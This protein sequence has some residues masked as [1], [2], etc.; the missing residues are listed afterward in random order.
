MPYIFFFRGGLYDIISM[1][2]FVS[3][4]THIYDYYLPRAY[5]N[6][7]YISPLTATNKAFNLGK[8]SPLPPSEVFFTS[9]ASPT[10]N[11][12]YLLVFK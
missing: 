1:S 2:I 6:I 11:S 10:M 7:K 8:V 3:T 9:S 12:T 4:A 5:V